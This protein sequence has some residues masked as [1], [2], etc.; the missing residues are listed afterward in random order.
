MSE[1]TK[2]I[3]TESIE[4]MELIDIRFMIF[5]WELDLLWISENQRAEISRNEHFR[6]NLQIDW[7]NVIQIL[8]FIF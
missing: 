2:I 1:V 4:K 5:L 3:Y 7:S 6:E 8:K